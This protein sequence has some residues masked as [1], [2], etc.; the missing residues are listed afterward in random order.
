MDGKTKRFAHSQRHYGLVLCLLAILCL[1]ILVSCKK[2][3]DPHM[4]PIH[5][6]ATLEP[7][8]LGYFGFETYGMASMAGTL[9]ISQ[10][11][12]T[13][14]DEILASRSY[15]FPVEAT[16]AMTDTIEA[17]INIS[18]NWYI[19]PSVPAR[20]WTTAYFRISRPGGG[21]IVLHGQ[22]YTDLDTPA[23]PGPWGAYLTRE[24]DV[25]YVFFPMFLE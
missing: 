15:E 17:P 5:T 22:W 18:R 1:A 10:T 16:I 3:P 13:I 8:R 20:E 9:T 14:D 7:V 25:W 24:F 19:V 4:S 12:R 23:E 21:E 6:M 11:L 2:T